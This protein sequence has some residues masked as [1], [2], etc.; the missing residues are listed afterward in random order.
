MSFLTEPQWAS[1]LSCFLLG[2]DQIRI[3]HIRARPRKSIQA[4]YEVLEAAP[5]KPLPF[6]N[7]FFT[8]ICWDSQIFDLLNR[9]DLWTEIWRILVDGGIVF[10]PVP[11]CMQSLIK[12]VA[13][14]RSLGY[15]H[16]Q[17][18]VLLPLTT[19]PWSVIPVWPK[20][21]SR[22][23]LQHLSLRVGRNP[24]NTV[25]LKIAL[26]LERLGVLNKIIPQVFLAARKQVN[27][28]RGSS[29]SLVD[30]L[31]ELLRESEI[32]L[33]LS[34]GTGKVILPVFSLAG[35]ALAYVRLA[36]DKRRSALLKNEARV[37]I[38][39]EQ[40]H[41]DCAELPHVI[42]SGT[43]RGFFYVIETTVENGAKPSR[44]FKSIHLRWLCELFNQTARWQLIEDSAYLK[45]LQWQLDY[46]STRVETKVRE[47]LHR[48][49][50]DVI[51][52]LKQAGLLPFGVSQREFSIDHSLE[53][54]DK[55]FVVDWEHARDE[56]PPYFD[57]FH[58][59]LSLNPISTVDAL[60]Q[61]WRNLFFQKGVGQVVIEQYSRGIG[62]DSRLGYLFLWLYIVDQLTIY[63]QTPD[64][65]RAGW[66]I[67]MLEEMDRQPYFAQS[68]WL[69]GAT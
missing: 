9:K 10:G 52:Q 1:L 43:W 54:G 65:L 25:G 13:F 57:L 49:I 35:K 39:L 18:Y 21:V 33:S 37:L 32:V 27:S 2:Q 12:H 8:A 19:R 51:R 23:A 40:K 56:Y 11:N 55:L 22:G 38:R 68:N 14:L 61:H 41:F 20:K 4:S 45:T 53:V 44:E 47:L 31:E 67:R 59:L 66:M 48:Q 28:N 7:S 60:F 16:I 62:L 34:L 15:S 42:A 6:P 29:Q 63:L 58:C 3:L 5:E 30:I 69:G 24:K 64:H 46:I 17:G 50:A 26:L 36:H